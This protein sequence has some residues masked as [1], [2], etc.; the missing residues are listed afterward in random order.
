MVQRYKPKNT[1]VV[2]GLLIVTFAKQ[3]KPNDIDD[4]VDNLNT[5]LTSDDPS[6][7]VDV[8]LR[9]ADARLLS[10][11]QDPGSIPRNRTNDS[12]RFQIDDDS[13]PSQSKRI[14]YSKPR[15]KNN[16]SYGGGRI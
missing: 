5:L 9:V 12:Q 15:N 13:G 2:N 3:L 14:S 10:E 8:E 6:Q 16:S 1:H 7:P 4:I 11:L